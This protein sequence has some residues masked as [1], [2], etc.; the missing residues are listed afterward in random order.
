MTALST[1]LR[2]IAELAHDK[3]TGPAQP[4]TL[5]EIRTLAYDAL[6]LTDDFV[7]KA[8]VVAF[9]EALHDQAHGQHN[10]YAYAA[11]RIREEL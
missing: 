7:S 8:D 11:R 6:D 4:D 2:H 1:A 3:S 5:W 10:H 9:L